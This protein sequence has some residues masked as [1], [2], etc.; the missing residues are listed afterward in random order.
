MGVSITYRNLCNGDGYHEDGPV[1]ITARRRATHY[2]FLML[3][4]DCIPCHTNY[5]KIL[6]DSFYFPVTFYFLVIMSQSWVSRKGWKVTGRGMDR[7][8]SVLR[9]QFSCLRWSHRSN[10]SKLRGILFI[11]IFLCSLNFP[12]FYVHITEHLQ[13]NT[14]TTPQPS[15]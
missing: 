3:S 6:R 5:T 13:R 7:R 10:F 9:D 11:S 14:S 8:V 1:R 2:I 15:K 4:H 12:Y